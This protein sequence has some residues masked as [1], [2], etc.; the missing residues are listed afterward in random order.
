VQ[1]TYA[2]G[3]KGK[4]NRKES[5]GKR[6]AEEMVVG[7]NG[8]RKKRQIWKTAIGKTAEN[9]KKGKFWPESRP[10]HGSQVTGC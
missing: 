1:N 10:A 3:K 9:R 7:K 4:G 5:N 8:K 6:Q 2:C